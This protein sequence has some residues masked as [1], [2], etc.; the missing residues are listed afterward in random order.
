MNLISHKLIVIYHSIYNLTYP[1]IFSLPFHFIRSIFLRLFI[2]HLGRQTYVGRSLDIRNP[3]GVYIGDN[4]VINKRVVLDGRGQLFIGN[5]VD[6]AQDVQIW[7]EQHDYNDDYHK[8]EIKP[9][10]VN[11]YAWISSR[12]TILP[13]VTIAKG[14]VVASGAVVTKNVEEMTVVGGVPSKPIAMRSSQLKY[15]LNFSARYR[16]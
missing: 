7:T 4:C 15:N 1:I 13:G 16:F 8:L 11:D 5:N 3:W 2:K 10:Y 9:V 12:A 14:G 6:I